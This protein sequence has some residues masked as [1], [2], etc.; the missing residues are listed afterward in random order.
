MSKSPF[1]FEKETAELYGALAESIHKARPSI[2]QK[3][4]KTY[5]DNIK[6]VRRSLYDDENINDFDW[7]ADDYKDIV[8]GLEEKYPNINTVKMI[9]ACI[10]VV[11]KAM[12]YPQSHASIE[13]Y[14]RMMTDLRD[15]YEDSRKTKNAKQQ[16]RWATMAE[17]KEVMRVKFLEMQNAGFFDKEKLTARQF[18]QLREYVAV[19]LYVIDETNPPVRADYTP[20]KIINESAFNKLSDDDKDDVNWLIIKNGGSKRFVFYETKTSKKLGVV[21][22][23]IGPKLNAVLNLWLKRNKSEWL[24]PRSQSKDESM[25]PDSFSKMVIRF[26]ENSSIGKK[27]GITM[28]RTI[29]ISE[30]FPREEYEKRAEVAHK[31]GHDVAQQAKYSK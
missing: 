2:T 7:L 25:P 30:A 16:E 17:I 1:K 22:L 14:D 29:F 18:N 13:K 24:F 9:V 27:I 11:L 6:R 31:M 5:I 3:T 12:G 21:D 20:M 10:V 19:S 23:P 8:K 4:I 26:F 15:K 28:L